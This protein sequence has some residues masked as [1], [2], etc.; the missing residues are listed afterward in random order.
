MTAI[1]QLGYPSATRKIHI[2]QINMVYQI[3]IYIQLTIRKLS[4]LFLVLVIVFFRDIV[5]AGYGGYSKL[6]F[7]LPPQCGILDFDRVDTEDICTLP[8]F[9]S[10]RNLSTQLQ[11]PGIVSYPEVCCQLTEKWHVE[12]FCVPRPRSYAVIGVPHIKFETFL[13]KKKKSTVTGFSISGITI[14]D[15]ISI[16]VFIF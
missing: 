11:L 4:R 7:V 12:I 8:C 9:I 15:T 16:F 10:V 5:A 3:L 2:I 1:K 14:P 13:K 6:F